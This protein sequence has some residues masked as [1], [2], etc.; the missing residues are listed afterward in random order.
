MNID[1]GRGPA[2]SPRVYDF[3]DSDGSRRDWPRYYD[4]IMA[5]GKPADHTGYR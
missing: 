3:T 2:R 4:E 1:T 5:A